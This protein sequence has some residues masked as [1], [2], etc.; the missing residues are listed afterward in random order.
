MIDF[1][2][3]NGRIIINLIVEAAIGRPQAA[4]K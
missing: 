1:V 3:I 2:G 4:K